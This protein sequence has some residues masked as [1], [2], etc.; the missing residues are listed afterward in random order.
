MTNKLLLIGVEGK[1]RD[2]DIYSW[3]R[4]EVDPPLIGDYENVVIYMPSLKRDL[5]TTANASI[6]V[7]N[8]VHKGVTDAMNGTTHIYY[9]ASP[10]HQIHSNYTSFNLFPFKISYDVETGKTFKSKD[11]SL[12]Y[13]AKLTSWQV[14]FIDDA[15]SFS[16]SGLKPQLSSLARTNHEKNAAFRI[17]YYNV[18]AGAYAGV[19]DVLPSLFTNGEQSEERTINE[20]IDYCVP[21][22]NIDL[23]LP[24]RYQQ[25]PLPGEADL[26]MEDGELEQTIQEAQKRRNA[27]EKSLGVYQE[28]KGIVAFKGK[29]LEYCVD[30]VLKKLSIAYEPTNTNKE[31]GHLTLVDNLVVPVEIKGHETKGASENDLRQVIARLSDQTADKNVRGVLIVNPFYT[32]PEEEQ[33]S[34][35][36]FESSV[37]EQAKAFNIALLD[38]RILLQYLI[39]QLEE[40]NNALLPILSLAP[41]ET[42]FHKEPQ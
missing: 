32:L 8:T 35:K 37:I 24:E 38:T 19:L 2:S 16:N 13:L 22:S 30:I 5:F 10:I 7:I 4:M 18:N 33:A 40:G 36:A 41:G 23:R 39:I 42:H 26:R 1:Y 21:A 34:K 28:F 15:S 6:V 31:D 3:Q 17:N 11:A 27:I 12:P 29:S 25:I 14:A 20:L 9:I